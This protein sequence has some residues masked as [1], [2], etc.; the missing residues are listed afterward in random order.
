MRYNSTFDILFSDYFHFVIEK[1]SRF[2]YS[3]MY[4]G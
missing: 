4:G 3:V 2:V 1:K